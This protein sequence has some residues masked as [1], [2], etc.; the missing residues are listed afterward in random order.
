VS[1]SRKDQAIE[2]F[3]IKENTRIRA[4]SGIPAKE[5]LVP[6]SVKSLGEL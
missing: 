3:T 2:S 1:C 4:A 6:K 5:A